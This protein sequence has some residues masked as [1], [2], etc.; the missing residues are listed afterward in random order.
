MNELDRLIIHPGALDFLT[1]TDIGRTAGLPVLGEAAASDASEWDSR[2][3]EEHLAASREGGG[4]GG[5]SFL[6]LFFSFLYFL[7]LFFSATFGR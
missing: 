4:I 7:F 5:L 1:T 3:C 2:D 6:L